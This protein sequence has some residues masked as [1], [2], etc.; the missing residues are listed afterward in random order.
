M[1]KGEAVARLFVPL[2]SLSNSLMTEEV[3]TSSFLFSSSVTS[4]R[5]T[6][7]AYEVSTNLVS[8]IFLWA[9]LRIETY[10]G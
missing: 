10:S 9:L 1:E 7:F 4:R 6:S 5:A 2:S 8:S 3:K